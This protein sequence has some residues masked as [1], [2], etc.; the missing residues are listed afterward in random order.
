MG[1]GRANAR[2]WIC[3]SRRA[4][5]LGYLVGSLSALGCFAQRVRAASHPAAGAAT[6]LRRPP[7]AG[8]GARGH[9]APLSNS[10]GAPRS[11]AGSLEAAYAE[12]PRP[13]TSHARGL[14]ARSRARIGTR[15]AC[16]DA[17]RAS[18]PVM[19]R[20]DQQQKSALKP[21]SHRGEHA[22]AMCARRA[23]MNRVVTVP[24]WPGRLTVRHRRK[25]GGRVGG[26]AA[27]RGAAGVAG[28]DRDW[29]SSRNVGPA[30]PG[31]ERVAPPNPRLARRPRPDADKPPATS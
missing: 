1:S 25:G 21:A 15:P 27:S 26:E 12:R 5:S 4:S 29:T 18:R 30:A 16:R 7:F 24:V 9:A 11:P 31:C 28:P 8:G 6:R 13:T 23:V 19:A 22:S 17:A 3:T 10:G 14:T 2:C 20:T